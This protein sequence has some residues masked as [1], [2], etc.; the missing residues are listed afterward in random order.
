MR[1]VLNPSG[2]QTFFESAQP[3]PAVVGR[4]VRFIG[5]LPGN[6]CVERQR[7]VSVTRA[8]QDFIVTYVIEALPEP[9]IFGVRPWCFWSISARCPRGRSYRATANGSRN[10]AGIASFSVAVKVMPHG[11]VAIE[12]VR[13]GAEHYFMTADPAD[14]DLLDRGVLKDWL[15]TG[16]S[17]A[18]A[19]APAAG[20][21]NLRAVCRFYG[22]PSAGLD[23]HF[24]L[25]RGRGV[26]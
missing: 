6:T 4:A 19:L 12:F 3:N 15:P 8:D 16:R 22:L 18:V 25:G 5:F 1:H 21:G 14:I 11:R 10:G 17:F 24:L 7:V 23:S 20:T 9:Q 26:H 13:S 2:A